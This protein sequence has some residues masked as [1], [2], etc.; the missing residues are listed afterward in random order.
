M[1]GTKSFL[2]ACLAGFLQPAESRG[3]QRSWNGGLASTSP[4]WVYYVVVLLSQRYCI[5][6]KIAFLTIYLIQTSLTRTSCQTNKSVSAVKTILHYMLSLKKRQFQIICRLSAEQCI[7]FIC[8]LT[9]FLRISRTIW[10]Q[11]AIVRWRR[12]G[13]LQLGWMSTTH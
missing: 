1:H 3:A 11:D 6:Q 12:T 13:Y 10:I 5:L 8:G 2:H 9:S 4:L 7:E